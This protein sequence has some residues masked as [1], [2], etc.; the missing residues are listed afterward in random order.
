MIIASSIHDKGSITF[1]VDRIKKSL[2]KLVHHEDKKIL[3]NGSIGIALFPQDATNAKALI[4]KADTA[5]YHAKSVGK[6]V[7]KFY[8]PDMDLRAKRELKVESRLNLAIENND[9]RLEFQPIIDLEL[10]KA[11]AAE[12]LLRWKDEELGT[13]NPDEFI[14]VAEKSG[15]IN[16]VGRFVLRESIA[17]AKIWGHLDDLNVSVNF[18]CFQFNSPRETLNEVKAILQEAN[19]PARKLQIEIT[20]SLM[21]NN[22]QEVLHVLQEMVDMNIRL[23]ID[24]FGAGYSALNYIH[25]YPFSVIKID[26]DIVMDI[27]TSKASRG[28]V[29]AILSMAKE[30]ELDVVAE[31][32]ENQETLDFLKKHGCRYAQGFLFSKSL[33]TRDLLC[34]LSTSQAILD[35][36]SE[37]S[38]GEQEKI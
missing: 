16:G 3:L 9:L 14:Q 21:F 22:S 18:S 13:V 36:H 6:G 34:Y 37:E 24:D 23:C 29:V 31:G 1:L 8:N 26:K 19:F 2:S 28:L 38:P 4:E 33:S 25:Q 5:M 15:A 20:E 27:G 32:V 11:V 12:S 7:A 17:Q 35:S 10:N 30:L